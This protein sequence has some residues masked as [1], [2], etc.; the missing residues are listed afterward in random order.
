MLDEWDPQLPSW[1]VPKSRQPCQGIQSGWKG[2]PRAG[3]SH[4]SHWRSSGTSCSPTGSVS[5]PDPPLSFQT[6]TSLT[7]PKAP[8]RTHSTPA[9]KALV[10]VPWLPICVATSEAAAASATRRASATLCV[11]CVT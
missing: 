2:R 9:R 4:R 3:P 6:C 11:S 8:E 5:A 10:A 7:S 1:P